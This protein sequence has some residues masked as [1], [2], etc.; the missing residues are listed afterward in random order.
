MNKKITINKILNLIEK[1]D[2]K[3]EKL[4]A[5][6]KDLKKQ[7]YSVYQS[8]FKIVAN[9]DIGLKEAESCWAKIIK[10]KESLKE[11]FGKEANLKT[12]IF[13]YFLTVEDKISDYRII[14]E[15]KLKQLIEA[16]LHDE[17]THLYN[18]RFMYEILTR[19][20]ARADRYKQKISVLLLDI[21]NFKDFNDNYGHLIGD[22]V[23]KEFANILKNNFRS[24]DF[25]TRYG[26]DEFVTILPETDTS[27]ALIVSRR[28]SKI[29]SKT[30]FKSSNKL[31]LKM[32]ISGGVASFPDDGDS[33]KDL[34]NK[35]DMANYRAK[36][37]GKNRIYPFFVERRRFKRINIK[38]TVK[39]SIVKGRRHTVASS[40]NISAS[41][42]L[43]ETNKSI[44]IDSVLKIR[45]KAPK[46]KKEMKL[47]G[48]VV[49]IEEIADKRFEIGVQFIEIDGKDRAYIIKLG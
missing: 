13:D 16:S 29:V 6:F 15:V 10:H 28:I 11:K 25:I 32:T 7:K 27:G 36:R 19:E 24:V 26:G 9:M 37:E 4:R 2:I 30:I 18:R 23:L 45:I 40:K 44:P 8:I 49:R 17:L 14:S 43:F 34:L 42:I 47:I 5:E 48:K 12:A 38:W 3:R 1:D 46:L 41:G 20:I 31:K 33:A 39:F 21:D 35:A 22:F